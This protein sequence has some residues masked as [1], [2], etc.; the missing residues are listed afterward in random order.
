MNIEE[1]INMFDDIIPYKFK[2]KVGGLK[3][4]SITTDK[5]LISYNNRKGKV[6]PFYRKNSFGMITDYA[7]DY[8]PLEEFDIPV[9]LDVV[10]LHPHSLKWENMPKSTNKKWTEFSVRILNEEKNKQYGYLSLHLTS[11]GDIDHKFC[12]FSNEDGTRE[13]QQFISYQ[14]N[15]KTKQV[16]PMENLSFIFYNLENG[17]EEQVSFHKENGVLKCIT[18][19]KQGLKNHM[20]DSIV[21]SDDEVKEKNNF[22]SRYCNN[23]KV[24]YATPLVCD[25]TNYIINKDFISKMEE[26]KDLKRT[27]TYEGD[28]RFDHYD[29]N[30]IRKRIEYLSDPKNDIFASFYGE[31]IGNT[32]IKQD[33]KL[34]LIVETLE[35]DYHYFTY[36]DITNTNAFDVDF[37]H[38][39]NAGTSYYNAVKNSNKKPMF[40]VKIENGEEILAPMEEQITDGELESFKSFKS[41]CTESFYDIYSKKLSVLNL[42]KYFNNDDE[43]GISFTKRRSDN[44]K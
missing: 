28:S 37:Y 6:Y 24:E 19:N 36:V 38:N 3:S 23:V 9:E 4:D 10:C 40:R 8:I 39:R 43:K 42:N 29:Y 16:I 14:Y 44:E 25:F 26:L 33:S 20:Y 1:F 7:P 13:L 2:L 31:Y 30:E 11:A 21:W 34:I 17:L 32:V 18:I 27:L 15:D 12:S 35:D 41:Y 22:F 5:N